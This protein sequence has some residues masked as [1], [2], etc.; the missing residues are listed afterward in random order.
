MLRI[1]L[2]HR[3]ADID[4]DRWDATGTEPFSSHAVLSA[5]EAS[6]MKGVSMSYAVIRDTYG[7]ILGCAPYARVKID[8]GRL[9]HGIFRRLI[10]LARRVAPSFMHTSLFICGTPLSVGNP[11]VRIADGADPVIVLKEAAGLLMELAQEEKVPWC[12]LK[13]LPRGQL[14]A[15]ES[16]A[17][18]GWLLAASE[19]N[20]MIPIRWKCYREYLQSLRS[21]YRYKIRKSQRKFQEKNIR[22]EILPLE[23]GYDASLHGLYEDVVD[24][25]V[26]VLERLTPSFFQALGR[27]Y[28]KQACLLRFTRNGSVVGWVVVLSNGDWV[29]DL[30]HGIDYRV[31]SSSDLYFNQL[32]QT[33][34]FAIDQG[35]HHLSLGQST[36]TAKTRFGGQAVP[37]WIAVRH[38]LPFV[39]AFL[40]RGSSLLFPSPTVPRRKV[41]SEVEAS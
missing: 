33:V 26:V 5:L 14:A 12:A 17:Q 30:F 18:G 27:S 16:L 28:G 3:I 7:R 20:F 41:F 4:A 10:S 40:Q 38:R 11:P 34:R 24:H 15:A 9:T 23:E 22:V 35:A 39:N 8:A 13:E 32:A 1:T 6:G 21:H 2:H 19:P 25:A 31:N 36:E 29:Y 37:L